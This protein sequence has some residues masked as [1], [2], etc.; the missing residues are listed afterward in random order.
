MS[1]VTVRNE[2]AGRAEWLNETLL[3]VG[4]SETAG[5]STA[6]DCTMHRMLRRPHMPDGLAESVTGCDSREVFDSQVRCAGL[7]RESASFAGNASHVARR[8]RELSS[9]VF[10]TSLL[11][12]NSEY[13]GV[14][15][16]SFDSSEPLSRSLVVDWIG[17]GRGG[18]RR[19]PTVVPG[20]SAL[21]SGVFTGCGSASTGLAHPFI[22]TIFTGVPVGYGLSGPP[23][24][25]VSSPQC[26]AGLHAD[27]RPSVPRRRTA[28]ASSCPR[29]A[30]LPPRAR[31][32]NGMTPL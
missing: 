30:S 24:N 19:P 5:L 11:H 31:K 27:S 7:S 23:W 6:I 14:S 3:G 8:D 16:Y 13:D 1:T 28:T 2:A 32:G 17:C 21:R 29:A 20:A 4:F 18:S 12:Y 26:L 10:S 9:Q 22:T 25:G 15:L